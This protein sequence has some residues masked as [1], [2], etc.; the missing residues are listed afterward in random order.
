MSM[1]RL[2]AAKDQA[3]KASETIRAVVKSL[4]E[5]QARRL[6]AEAA[7]RVSAVVLYFE[8]IEAEWAED[9]QHPVSWHGKAKR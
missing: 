6:L 1:E 2:H 7:Y 3:E 5:G 9:N 4:P 8:E